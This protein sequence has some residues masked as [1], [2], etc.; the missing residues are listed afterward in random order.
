MGWLLED[1]K[2]VPDVFFHRIETVKYIMIPKSKDLKTC[3]LKKFGS[4]VIVFSSRCMLS[5]INLNY[6]HVFETDKIE[7]VVFKR[8]LSS[9]LAAHLSVAKRMPEATLCIR[10]V[11]A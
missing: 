1:L 9:E 3:S 4:F 2:N 8:V 11:I 10:H 5:T 7:D 6:Q